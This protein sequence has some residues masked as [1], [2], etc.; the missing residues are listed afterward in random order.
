MFA[1]CIISPLNSK[2]EWRYKTCASAFFFSLSEKR[3]MSGEKE[4]RRGVAVQPLNCLSIDNFP[5]ENC[6]E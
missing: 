5:K 4:K 3:K 6:R 1:G 2:H